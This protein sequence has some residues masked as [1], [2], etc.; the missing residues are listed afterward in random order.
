[1]CGRKK[2]AKGGSGYE[3]LEKCKTE[4]GARSLHDAALSLDFPHLQSE[5]G[6]AEWQM[7]LAKEYYYHMSCYREICK[8][9]VVK[10][11]VSSDAET[12]FHEL[13]AFIEEKVIVGCDVLRMSSLC[14]QHSEIAEHLFGKEHQTSSPKLQRLKE[15]IQKF[16][17]SRVGFW[18]P[19]YGSE[20]VF[21]NSVEKGQLVEVAVKAKLA[22]CKW[23]EKSTEEK[24]IEVAQEIRKELLETPN[25][26][27][28]WP[29]PEHELLCKET[30]IPS[31]TTS[32]LEG[33]L[34]KKPTKSPKV[35]R[36]VSSIGQ[37]LIY[38]ANNG[39]KKTSK[40]ATFPFSMKRKTGSKIVIN[41]TH[42]FGHRVSYDDVL[43]L[44][45]YLAM[46]HSKDEVHRSFSPAIIQPSQFVTF[47][48]DNNDINPESLKGL[49]LHC[50]NGIVIQSSRVETNV[51]EYSSTDTSVLLQPCK[52]Q[53]PK[54]FQA[55]PLEMPSYVQVKRRNTEG[56]TNVELSMHQ[57][58]IQRSRGVYTLWVIARSQAN[59]ANLEQ[60]IPG[61]T[62]F[63]YLMCDNDSDSYHKIGYLPS[64]NKSPTSH[65]TVLELLS[66][67]KIKAG[68]LGLVE[69]DVVLDMA[70]YAKA[71]E[72]MMNPKYVDLKQFIV[73]RLGG[74][75][76]M[77]IF[78]AVIGKRFADAGLRDIV[79][80]ANLLGESSV[81]Q[82]LK[83][84]HYNA[85]RIL[86][87]I[88][89]AVKRHMLNSFEQ[90]K[91]DQPDQID[92]LSYE[93]LVN[94]AELKSFIFSPTR[95]SLETLSQDHN[96]V[97]DEIHT[98]EDSILN[99]SLGPTASVWSSF[100]QIVQILL[101][102][103][104]SI[105]TGNWDLHLQ[106]TEN[107]LPWM[108]SYDRP[109][110][111]C[112][113][114]YY[115]VTMKKLPETHPAIHQEFEAGHFS[116][117]RQQGRFNKIPSD[118]AIEQ[119]VNREQKC[120]GGIVGYSTSEGTVQRWVL[121]SHI[122]AKCQSKMDEFLGMTEAKCVTKDLAKK[123]ILYDE[124]CIFRSYDLIKEWG[125]PFKE[126]S[127]L[128]HLSSGLQSSSDIQDDMINAE[129]STVQLL[130]ETD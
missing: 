1:M 76:M 16:F 45:T 107:M 122:A 11:V 12:V 80:E 44:E 116:V 83:G 68:K 25:T 109:N 20:Y 120:A 94:S 63:N 51:P 3:S 36:L 125:T 64:I 128:V 50:T 17:G 24:T 110:Y 78:I 98:Y 82:M 49:S 54:T 71:V 15:K 21:N 13:A 34:T 23:E 42:K 67:S 79:I 114:T 61:W 101:D 5:I 38:H 127:C 115:L 58:E 31:L 52:K 10:P 105:K 4:N 95:Q 112:F 91:R 97:V 102:F 113:L 40:H 2:T 41:W 75:H 117:R 108:F 74:F 66:Q 99:G 56:P 22:N 87:Y 53:K 70:I 96:K 62:C 59:I 35:A 43:I 92:E 37:D 126:N 130:G 100:L 6:N 72:V 77:C 28:S 85:M 18:C 26:F 119:T 32:L 93:E 88:Y 60:Q 8:K 47:I 106:S 81:D 48:W 9:R 29:P 129:K 69:T 90:W 111:A 57:E 7:I 33:I 73:L 86:K 14:K 103:A 30:E 39:R 27:S 46:E 124:E 123:R 104:R 89:E 121:T 55:L 65:D 118:Q 84:K 19:K